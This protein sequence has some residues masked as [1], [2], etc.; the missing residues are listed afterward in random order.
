MNDAPA[1][2]E[3]AATEPATPAETAAAGLE[4]LA[5]NKAW[6]SDFNG[7][8]GRPAQLAAVK[9]KADTTR[10]AF[11]PEPNRS[12]DLSAQVEAGLE[13]TDNI[14]KASAE[15]MV[16][17]QD[18][19]EYNFKWEGAS[20]ME[21]EELQSMDTMAKESAFA[22]NANPAYARTT[23]ETMDRALARPEGS[24]IP[25]TSDDLDDHLQA[26]LGDQAAATMDA[27][28]ATMQKMPADGQKWL[29]NSLSKLDTSTAAWVVGRLASVHR[30]NG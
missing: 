28:L 16:P 5:A 8:N 6:Q 23:I 29:Q 11:N 4:T 18:V 21:F 30:A 17:A 2:T 19:S 10:A 27:A 13:A 26:Q 9:L 24:F 1:P 15:A 12:P 25:T 3:P 7:D 20:N 14:T 22:V